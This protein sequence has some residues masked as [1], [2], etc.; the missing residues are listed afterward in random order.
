[1]NCDGHSQIS[2]EINYPKTKSK[3]LSSA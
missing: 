1:M 3:R 2:I